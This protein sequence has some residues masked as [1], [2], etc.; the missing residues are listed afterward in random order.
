MSD[1]EVV[2]AKRASSVSDEKFKTTY[3][4][5]AVA[6]K[7]NV[8]IADSLGMNTTSLI[9]RASALRAQ[10]ARD[11]IKFPY[12]KTLRGQSERK[13]S[14]MSNDALKAFLET[15]NGSDVV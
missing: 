9:S 11:G 15:L 8:E 3:A 12:A 2:K 4:Q 6:G 13:S 1:V 7:S 5:M 10:L 14:K